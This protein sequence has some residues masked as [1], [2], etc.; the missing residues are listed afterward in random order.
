MSQMKIS[1]TS[2]ARSPLPAKTGSHNGVAAPRARSTA[3]RAASVG[4]TELLQVATD[5]LTDAQAREMHRKCR[6]KLCE[7]LPDSFVVMTGANEVPRNGIDVTFPFRQKSDFYYLTGVDAPG[8]AL[9]LDTAAH[10]LTLLA[11]EL[12]P[13]FAVWVGSVP[14]LDDIAQRYGADDVAF[15]KKGELREAV[16]GALKKLGAADGGAQVHVDAAGDLEAA[17]AVEGAA[18]GGDG[19]AALAAAMKACRVAKIE[20]ELQCIAHAN[21]V[22]GRAHAHLMAQCAPGM[23]EFQM[24]A[25]FRHATMHGGLLQLGYPVIAAAGKNGAIMHSAAGQTAVRDQEL[26]LVDA[27]AE[28]RCYTAD[29]TRTWPCGSRGFGAAARDVYGTCLAMQELGLERV[30]AGADW[31]E[32][33]AAV[34]RL[35][36]EGLLDVG[37][38]RGRVDDMLERE[39]DKLFMPHNLGHYLGLDVHDVGPSG[40]VPETLEDGAVVTVEPGVYFIEALLEP[41]LGAGPK[42]EFLNE[43]VIRN[44]MDMG[45]VRIEDNV[46]V[47]ETGHVNLTPAECVKAPEDVE[48]ACRGA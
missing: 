45:G 34:R 31:K 28:H 15:Y 4:A 23:R 48:A 43:D 8:F 2:P 14:T 20:E 3:P 13:E 27:G 40:P 6:G 9:V 44:M 46:A 39:I 32:T 38:V 1:G 25:A 22:S 10:K 18:A 26:V 12:P 35:M 16:A 30:K 33:N 41:A 24:E 37:V 21:L 42:K 19:D 7:A 17:A 29:I 11:P 47:T 36:L 5:P